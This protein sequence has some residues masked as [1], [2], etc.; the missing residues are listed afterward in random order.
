MN[1]WHDSI[2]NFEVLLFFHYICR[3]GSTRFDA[4]RPAFEL[5]YPLDGLLIHLESCFNYYNFLI[6]ALFYLVL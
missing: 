5:V 6:N 2:S 1:M 3:H 4:A